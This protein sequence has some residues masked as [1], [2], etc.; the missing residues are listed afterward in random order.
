GVDATSNVL[1]GRVYGVPVTGTMA[2]S[3]IQ[4]HE[5]EMA[6][7]RAFVELYPDTILLVDTYDT[8]EGVEH[9]IRL[10]EELGSG[11]RVRGVRL[12]SGDLAALARETRT[13]LD[14]AGLTGVE[15]FA[16]GGLD[17]YEVDRLVR[18]GAP[19]DGFGVG[20]RMGTSADAPALDM[21]YKL[22]HYAGQGRLKLSSGKRILPGPKQVWR[23]AEDGVA[24][25][26]RITRADETAPG[27]PLLEPVMADGERLA[28][29]RRSLDEARA[30]AAAS[31]AAFPARIRALEPADP[32]FPVDVS[33]ALRTRQE[34]VAATVAG[35]AD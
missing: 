29:G 17:E 33:D 30:H 10:A 21:A 25:R 16:S 19:I 12:D 31:V 35:E 11:F 8:L 1:A 6:A 13:M 14:G 26:D 24:V 3:Y 5:S 18:A 4:A 7:F 9:V 15:I 23:E 2:H 27:R 22:T 20:T 34:G 32:P 28:A